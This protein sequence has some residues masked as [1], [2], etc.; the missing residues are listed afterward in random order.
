MSRNANQKLKLLVLRQYLEEQTDE[1]HPATTAQLIQELARHEITAERKSIYDDM[2]ALERFGLDVQC[3]RGAH[4][5]WFIGARAFELPELKL[6]VDAVQSSRFLSKGKSDSLIRK[7]EGL[8][9]VHQA[10]Q[11]QRQV[12]VD[13]RVK[14]MNE[15]IYYTVDKLHTAIATGK[16]ISFRYFDY[17]VAKEKV[18]RRDGGRY[19]VSPWG[20]VW[21]NENYYLVAFEG[22]HGE[23]RH[24]RVDKM[25]ALAVTSLPRERGGETGDFDMAAY[26]Q[27][28]FAM[29][30]GQEATVRLRCEN[31]LVNV[32][33][34]RFGRDVILVPDGADHFTVTVPLVVSPQ[35]FGWLFGLG[36]GVTLE[37]PRWA[38]DQFRT[39][40][41]A[42]AGNCAP[43]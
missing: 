33:L 38:A 11:L 27:K 9:S 21:N 2:A 14:A 18:F 32:V 39:Q 35:F 10:R 42:V 23:M 7:L 13:R 30:S 41:E 40:L 12:F 15:S 17:N 6:L 43:A 26:A 28:H 22:E 29:F 4:P 3:R 37:A 24:Y 5:G 16:Q 25:D 19:V 34:D 31:S 1:D 8:S 20:L 36:R